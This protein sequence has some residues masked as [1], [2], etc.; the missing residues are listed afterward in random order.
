MGFAAASSDADLADVFA[1]NL[2]PDLAP[3]RV[4]GRSGTLA[5]L[6]T[7]LRGQPASS[8]KRVV[9]LHGGRV[10]LPFQDARQKVHTRASGCRGPCHTHLHST[11]AALDAHAA[12]FR[13]PDA[14]FL[15][16]VS[17]HPVCR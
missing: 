5:S 6:I 1:Q 10:H 4:P 2:E 12:E 3:W 17:D 16:A 14:V 13:L 8:N 9:V 11:L 7:W 15:L